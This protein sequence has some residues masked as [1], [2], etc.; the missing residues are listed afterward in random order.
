MIMKL[1]FCSLIAILVPH[2]I[3]EYFLTQQPLIESTDHKHV[4]LHGCYMDRKYL[5]I[6]E[7]IRRKALENNSIIEDHVDLSDFMVGLA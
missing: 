6:G 1:D 3:I 4:V 7:S 2:S 5:V